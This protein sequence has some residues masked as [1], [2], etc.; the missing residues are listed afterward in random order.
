[1]LASVG[2]RGNLRTNSHPMKKRVSNSMHSVPTAA[3]SLL[4]IMVLLL[5]GC[6]SHSG[7]PKASSKAYEQFVSTFY[8]GLS[9]L[10][11]GN[12]TLADSSLQ[13]AT[14]IAPGEP[15]A[16]ADWGILALR[17]RNFDP[18]AERFNRALKL[19]PQNGRIYFLL[20]LLNSARGD[21]Q[22]GH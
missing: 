11:V 9:A 20:G 2:Y 1:M 3:A 16:W 22:G 17:Q 15:A 12:D 4:A 13:Q 14:Q 18:A 10:Q 8:V 19:V 7:L 6:H 5:S 21:S